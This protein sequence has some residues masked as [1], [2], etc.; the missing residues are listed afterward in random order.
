M[1]PRVRNIALTLCVF[2]SSLGQAQGDQSL[3]NEFGNLSAKE[4]ARIAKKEATDAVVDPQYQ[5]IMRE[6]EELFQQQ[7]YDDALVKYQEARTRRPLNV[8]PK[9]KIQ[10]LQALIAKRDAAAAAE[11]GPEQ[12]K[13]DTIVPSTLT[14]ET[15]VTEPVPPAEPEIVPAPE[16][17]KTTPVVEKRPVIVAAE[18]RTLPTPLPQLPEGVHERTY[19]EGRAIVLERSV[20]HGARTEVYRKVSHPWGQVVHFRDGIT[21]SEREWNKALSGQ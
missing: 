19:V 14:V 2:A 15:V 10:D 5:S 11:P 13:K 7:R 12:V 21:I 1:N 9:V 3:T 20:V 4:R 8:Y 17:H 16:P 18:Q 6:A